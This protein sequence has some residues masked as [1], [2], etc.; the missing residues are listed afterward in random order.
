M[1]TFETPQGPAGVVLTV[2]ADHRGR[3]VLGPGGLL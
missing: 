3:L 1:E 2:P